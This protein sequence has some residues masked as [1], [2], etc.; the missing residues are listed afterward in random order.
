MNREVSYRKSDNRKAGETLRLTMLQCPFKSGEMPTIT[1]FDMFVTL[2]KAYQSLE[3]Q[4][5]VRKL[6]PNYYCINCPLW[7]KTPVE[8]KEKDIPECVIIA[9]DTPE[10]REVFRQ[11]KDNAA[12]Q[13][14]YGFML[15]A[16]ARSK[17]EEQKREKEKIE[18]YKEEGRREGKEEG[19]EE[20]IREITEPEEKSQIFPKRKD[21]DELSSIDHWIMNYKPVK[22][23]EEQQELIW[24]EF[25]ENG[26]TK[27]DIWKKYGVSRKVV[28]KI[29]DKYD[30]IQ[31]HRKQKQ[32]KGGDE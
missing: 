14:D 17:Y 6:F 25:T 2:C 20:A 29:I 19:K 15:I 7:G 16:Y 8:I 12:S 21:L 27:S 30:M 22:V 4:R 3:E 13:T 32:H 1:M 10:K 18:E 5:S 28:A 11:L 31:K 9:D 23:S 24:K 26:M